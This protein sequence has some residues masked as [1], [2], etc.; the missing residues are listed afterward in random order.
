MNHLTYDLDIWRGAWPWANLD[1][2]RRSRSKSQIL[3]NIYW[4]CQNSRL[5]WLPIELDRFGPFWNRPICLSDISALIVQCY[6][7]PAGH[8]MSM[9]CSWTWPHSGQEAFCGVN[10]HRILP[11]SKI[12]QFML[13]ILLKLVFMIHTWMVYKYDNQI[14]DKRCHQSHN[15]QHTCIC[16]VLDP[17]LK[18]GGVC[19]I[20][21]KLRLK[22]HCE[23]V[24]QSLSRRVNI[25]GKFFSPRPFEKKKHFSR[26]DPPFEQ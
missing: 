26:V 7:I 1:L 22:K 25:L 23:I 3:V 20:L 10:V 21:K 15:Q 13:L 16:C 6:I 4:R 18:G 8:T 24:M 12:L 2:D 9:L 19:A 17:S 14:K 5:P 11:Y